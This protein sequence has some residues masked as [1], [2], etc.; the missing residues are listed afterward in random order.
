MVKTEMVLELEVVGTGNVKKLQRRWWV[1]VVI[2]G[3]LVVINDDSGWRS[4][5]A[6]ISWW[7]YSTLALSFSMEKPKKQRKG[8]IEKMT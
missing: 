8:E 2:E 6:A 4:P 3:K 5:C 1:L 7:L